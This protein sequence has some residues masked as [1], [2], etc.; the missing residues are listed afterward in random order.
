M[1]VA[2]KVHV[3]LSFIVLTWM[4]DKRELVYDVTLWNNVKS[5]LQS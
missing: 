4:C 5:T 3:I 1:L 2:T